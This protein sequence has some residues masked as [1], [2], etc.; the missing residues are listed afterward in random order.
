MISSTGELGETD[1]LISVLTKDV[2]ELRADQA[3]IDER[4]TRVTVSLQPIRS[5]AAA[6]ISPDLTIYDMQTGRLQ[7]RLQQLVRIRTSLGQRD[8]ISLKINEIQKEVTRLQAEVAEQNGELD[9]E[10]ASQLLADGMNTYLNEIKRLDPKS[11]TQDPVSVRFRE[12][13]FKILVGKNDFK[14]KLGYTLRLYFLIAY[15]YALLGLL[16]DPECNFPGLVI[17]DFPGTLEDGSSVADKEN[18]VVEPFIRLTAEVGMEKTQ[19]IAAG[20]SFENLEGANRIK[21]TRIWK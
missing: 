19:F 9:F 8:Q 7:E 11:W 3:K 20:S 10:H 12:R 15:H 2:D 5:A 21:L 1:E 4:I 18:F 16:K 13:G 14:A 17:L 6:I